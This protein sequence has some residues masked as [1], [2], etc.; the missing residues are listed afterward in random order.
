MGDVSAVALVDTYI[1]FEEQGVI[2]MYLP[3]LATSRT[4]ILTALVVLT[5]TEPAMAR[6]GAIHE[7][8]G[9]LGMEQGQQASI[10]FDLKGGSSFHKNDGD[11][12]IH[13]YGPNGTKKINTNELSSEAEKQGT[14]GYAGYSGDQMKEGIAFPLGKNAPHGSGQPM[15]SPTNDVYN[16]MSGLYYSR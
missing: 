15:H 5:L 10:H 12:R 3:S 4:Y 2:A 7:L 9:K 13:I 14:S 6:D 1:M 8:A 16:L 11:P